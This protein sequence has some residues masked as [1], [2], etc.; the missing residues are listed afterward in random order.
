[1]WKKLKVAKGVRLKYE[2][3]ERNVES[4]STLREG[5]PA[6][7]DQFFSTVNK[8]GSC[9]QPREKKKNNLMQI[10]IQGG[11]KRTSAKKRRHAE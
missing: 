8:L 9:P 10:K 1:M 2:K 5:I 7:V 11:K 6:L 4:G 3:E